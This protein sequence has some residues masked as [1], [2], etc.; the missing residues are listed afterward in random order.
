MALLGAFGW[1]TFAGAIVP[2][3]AIG[4]NWKRATPLAACLAIISSLLLNFLI[5]LFKVKLPYNIHGGALALM[6]SLTI[7]IVVFFLTPQKKIDADIETV[8]DM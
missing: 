5:E 6:V 2:T 8:M 4:F 3:V 7:F 1:S